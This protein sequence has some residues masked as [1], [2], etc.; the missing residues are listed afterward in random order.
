MPRY[1]WRLRFN[2]LFSLSP[3][4]MPAFV[5]LLEHEWWWVTD[6]LPKAA[7][8]HSLFSFSWLLLVS[9]GQRN[10]FE[11]RLCHTLPANLFL[12]TRGIL[13]NKMGQQ[14]L[15]CSTL[16]VIP[17][18]RAEQNIL[19]NPGCKQAAWRNTSISLNLPSGSQCCGPY[20]FFF[21]F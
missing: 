19:P 14:G 4:H 17:K 7:L 1:P 2:S 8:M 6:P 21:T 20:F 12:L 10:A 3:P 11:F 9:T 13:I 5:T 16:T 18:E 15:S